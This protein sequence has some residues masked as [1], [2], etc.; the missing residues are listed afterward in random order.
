MK[1]KRLHIRGGK[2]P[3][4]DCNVEDECDLHLADSI[5]TNND[6]AEVGVSGASVFIH[7]Q[8]QYEAVLILIL[9]CQLILIFY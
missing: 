7:I 6:I 4:D 3:P 5:G 1:K 2:R 8:Y 9:N